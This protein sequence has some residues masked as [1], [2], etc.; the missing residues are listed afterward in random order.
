MR[1]VYLWKGA[2]GGTISGK[3]NCWHCVSCEVLH[4]VVVLHRISLCPNW[5]CCTYECK[6]GRTEMCEPLKGIVVII[7]Q[8]RQENLTC[9][10]LK[11]IDIQS[12][13]ICTLQT[14]CCRAVNP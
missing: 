11:M 7:G 14:V 2:I 13:Q 4:R 6:I 1:V 3:M 5:H 9:P 8:I 10:F 12:V